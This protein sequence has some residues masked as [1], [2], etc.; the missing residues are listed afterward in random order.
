MYLAGTFSTVF[1]GVHYSVVTDQ[2]FK[3]S[4]DDERI[5]LKDLQGNTNITAT[6]VPEPGSLA[7][8]ELAWSA[9]PVWSLSKA[10]FSNFL[11]DYC[12]SNIQTLALV[13]LTCSASFF[14]SR[15]G[16]AH[17][18]LIFFGRHTGRTLPRKSICSSSFSFS[19]V[20]GT[21]ELLLSAA[22]SMEV[23]LRDSFR[24]IHFSGLVGPFRETMRMRPLSS[25]PHFP[26]ASA[27]IEP[28]GG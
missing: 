9:W 10:G 3:L 8:L 27:N 13:L 22:Q 6:V 19:P 20:V 1:D 26:R 24:L 12:R 17:D 15:E 7:L 16:I 21:H 2:M 18:T 28:S 25:S 14:P 5:C 11:N 23:R 4:F